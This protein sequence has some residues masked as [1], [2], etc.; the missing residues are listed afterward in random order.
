[1]FPS[2]V[3]SFAVNGAGQVTR[4]HFVKPALG[5]IYQ[6]DIFEKL[7]SQNC[8]NQVCGCHIGSVHRPENHLDELFGANLLERIPVGWPRVNQAFVDPARKSLVTL[9]GTRQT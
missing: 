2:C 8:P 6:E 1:M 9:S 3:P 5:N 7:T 4:C